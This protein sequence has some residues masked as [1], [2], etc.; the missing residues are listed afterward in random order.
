MIKKIIKFFKEFIHISLG[1]LQNR[2]L[3]VNGICFEKT[4]SYRINQIYN[5]YKSYIK[6]KC[7]KEFIVEEGLSI[8]FF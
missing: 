8:Y 7:K 1:F 6:E 3:F 2:K 4:R 5:F